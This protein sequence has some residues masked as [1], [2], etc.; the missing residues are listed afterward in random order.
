MDEPLRARILDAIAE[1]VPVPR[2]SLTPE[3]SLRGLGLTSIDLVEV[4]FALEERFGITFP[5][6]DP[7]LEGR[8][9][10]ELLETVER[11]LREKAG[12]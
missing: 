12:A 4:L 6:D 2:E 9:L 8:P 7:T 5:Y 1:Q 3:A 10:G 11:L